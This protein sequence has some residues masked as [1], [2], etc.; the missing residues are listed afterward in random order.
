M[1]SDVKIEFFPQ[2][3]ETRIRFVHFNF[4]NHG[5]AGNEYR[6]MLNAE[7]GWDYILDKYKNYCENN[8][9]VTEVL[10]TTRL[11]QSRTKESAVGSTSALGILLK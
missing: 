5:D 8:F 9:T 4:R 3:E 11:L 7:N 1:A 10:T 6:E 2:G